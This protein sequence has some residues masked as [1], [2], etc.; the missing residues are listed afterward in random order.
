M[1]ESRPPVIAV[2]GEAL[3][4]LVP[5]AP[6]ST[7]YDALP[8]G[9]P[10]NT[11]VALAR[12]GVPVTLLAR[13]GADGF[14]QQLRDHLAANGVDLSRSVAASERSSL[15]IV[16]TGA[17]G[18]AAYRFDLA[19]TADW[20]WTAEELATLPDPVVAVHA[21]SLALATPPGGAALEELL[22]RSRAAATVSIDPNLRPGLLTA[23]TGADVERW[24]GLADLLKVSSDD[25]ALL[26]PGARPEEVARRWAASGPGLVVVTLAGEGALVAV[27]DQ[28]LHRPARTVTVV[29]TVGAGDTFT[30]GLIEELW[31]RGRL[32]GRLDGLS[33][34]DAAAAAE[35]GLQA[36]AVTCSRAGADPPY[37]AEL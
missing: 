31:R 16:T 9:S 14:G 4:D 19:G 24:V 37:A 35:R 1:A 20:Q 2:C 25:L 33:V 29:D 23:T 26:H 28:V 13:F 8:G 30:A 5:T 22:R 12:L 21:G 11:A 34:E 6:G 32:G 17:D 18:S 15:A 36:A 3:I 27:G 10:A 7:T